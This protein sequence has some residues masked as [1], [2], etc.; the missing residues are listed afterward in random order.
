MNQTEL[1]VARIR[2][3]VKAQELADALDR[4][5]GS[6]INRE[7][8]RARVTLSDTL[9]ITQTLNL[10][11]EEFVVI[12]FDGDLPF[13]KDS[14]ENYNFR[15][16]PFPLKKARE[17]AGYSEEEVATKLGIPVSGYKDREKGRVPVTLVECAQLTKL[18]EL[19]FDEFNDIFF[20]SALPFRKENSLP[21]N[22]IIPQK[23]GEINAETSHSCRV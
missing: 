17:R 10:S 9:I 22:H 3:G 20:R 13:S 23:V 1:K 12:F 15:Q 16:T 21:Y 4:T 18:F 6:Y 5:I 14:D 8:G 2:R 7:N 19:S 11:L